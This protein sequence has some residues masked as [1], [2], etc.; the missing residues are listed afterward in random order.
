MSS[1]ADSAV[2]LRIQGAI[3]IIVIFVVGVLAGGAAER[4]RAS[5]ERPMRPFVQRGELP[6]PFQRIG[7]TEEQRT[8]IDEIFEGTR[9]AADSVLRELMPH[10][11]AIN[12]SVQGLIR[13]VLTDEQAAMLEEELARGGM[14]PEG[15]GGRWMRPF[16]PDS[17]PGGRRRPFP[18]D[19]GPNPQMRPRRPGG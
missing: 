7:L 16:M 12:D 14:R 9:P 1:G 19:S 17:P 2:R 18:P 5:R 4:I 3:L 15:F 10:L 8:Q 13:E 6:R 11:R